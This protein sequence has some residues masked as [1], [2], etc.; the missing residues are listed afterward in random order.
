VS[1][2]N[3]TSTSSLSGIYRASYGG[4]TG[5]VT[6]TQS[7]GSMTTDYSAWVT[8]GLAVT[9]SPNPVAASGGNATLSCKANQ[10]RSKYVK[11]NGV[12]TST[13]T[14]SQSVAVTAGWSKVS[15]SGSLSGATVSF[16]NNTSTSSLSGI[17]RAS[18]GGKTGDVTVSQY[19]G[20]VSYSYTFTFS[21]G[22]TATS[23]SGVDAGGSSKTFSINSTRTVSWNGIPTGTENITYS[24]SSNVSWAS[25]SGS[26]VTVGDN[27]GTTV[28][29][30]KITFTQA[31]SNKTITVTVLQLKKNS[32]IIG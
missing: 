24:G 23:W 32:V 22:T 19:G 2:G 9:A 11:W 27:P 5:D 14:E 12:T 28:R 10:T 8:S 1:F 30:G 4:K 21:D 26:T 3:N 17:Y 20:S 13:T 18:Y 25:A 15:G 29:S 6:V 7:A 31:E 16:G